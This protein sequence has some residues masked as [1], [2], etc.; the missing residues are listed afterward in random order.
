MTR[1]G[2]DQVQNLPDFI[3]SGGIFNFSMKYNNFQDFSVSIKKGKLN[4][5]YSQI[6]FAQKTLKKLDKL[7]IM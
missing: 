5:G 6:S 4:Y 1:S 3:F 2:P 7:L